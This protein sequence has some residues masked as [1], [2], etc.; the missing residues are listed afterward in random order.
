MRLGD[1]KRIF[2]KTPPLSDLIENTP[3][4]VEFTPYRTVGEIEKFSEKAAEIRERIPKLHPV[5]HSASGF[6][7]PAPN[8]LKDL[9]LGWSDTEH[10]PVNEY[11]IGGRRD[12]FK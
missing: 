3:S 6:T 11:Y 9:D 4:E 5:F 8:L 2:P 12:T 1:M 10:W 7:Q